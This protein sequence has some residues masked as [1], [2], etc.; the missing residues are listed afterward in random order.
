MTCSPTTECPDD[1]LVVLYKERGGNGHE[2][3]YVAFPPNDSGLQPRIVVAI[4]LGTVAIVSVVLYVASQIR[5]H[6]QVKRYKKRFVQ[7][8]ARNINI[9][10]SPSCISVDK[11]A[12]EVQHIGNKDGIITKEEL[13]KWMLDGKL[14]SV[15]QSMVVGE[16]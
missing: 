1:S 8:I 14:G 11:L 4:V 10:P 3:N 5:L 12:E 7:Q 6:A 9:G 2:C 13:L 15:L 16:L